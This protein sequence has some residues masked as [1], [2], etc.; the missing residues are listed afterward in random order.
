ML[1][2]FLNQNAL[3]WNTIKNKFP[4]SYI[5]DMLNELYRDKYFSKM[6]LH[7]GYHQVWVATKYTPK[8]TFK[9]HARC[10][11]FLIMLFRFTNAPSTFQG[12]MNQLFWPYLIKFILVF[13]FF[14]IIQFI[15]EIWRS[16]VN[17]CFKF[18]ELLK[19]NGFF[20]GVL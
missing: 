17:T 13:L 15:I 3:N 1:A 9:S 19:M 8:R 5:D 7:L 14:I 6:D 18:L 20:Y 11:E 2:S 12:L 10:Y 4:I 16:T